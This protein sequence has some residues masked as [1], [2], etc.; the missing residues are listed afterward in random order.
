MN[1]ILLTCL[2]CYLGIYA[3]LVIILSLALARISSLTANEFLPTVTVIVAARNEEKTIARC[4][5]SLLSVDYPSNK[6]EIVIVDHNS[7]DCTHDILMNYYKKNPHLRVLRIAEQ[8]ARLS[9]KA[10]A[11]AHGLENS[12]GEIIFLT[13]A[14]C[15][16]PT[17]WIQTITSYFNP[18]IDAI[19]GF[20]FIKKNKKS[21]L[22]EGA[23]CVD[24]LFLQSAAAGIAA[25]G[26]PLT[27]M[28]N[29][30]AFRRSAYEAV[31]GFKKLGFSITEDFTLLKAFYHKNRKSVRFIL[32][33]ASKVATRAE[34]TVSEIYQQ[35][36]RWAIGGQ[37]VH[38]I[39]KLFIFFGAAIHTLAFFSIFMMFFNPAFLFVW[40]CLFIC[41]F[42][43][44][45]RSALKLG[46][47]ISLKQ[48][49]SFELLFNFYS[50]S[51]VLTM[52]FIR[53]VKWKNIS[54][55][56]TPHILKENKNNSSAQ[57]QFGI[58]AEA[59]QK[60]FSMSDAQ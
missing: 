11:V 33:P 52:P 51:V 27:W 12:S 44:L 42:F 4:V 2:L 58:K 49:L 36:L 53:H 31:G 17:T 46:Q 29:N 7:Q 25:L 14:D 16:V 32:N 57:P 39:G 56:V 35:R 45:R 37:S 47:K 15:E 40:L 48:I 22:H 6:L 60:Q 23:Q 13:D 19:G 10:L 18:G 21:R 28:G 50:L 34:A 30:L 9:G 41:D 20:T 54:Y 55:T 43:F 26:R 59:Q 1:S 24:W 38:P 5:E 8:S 3:G